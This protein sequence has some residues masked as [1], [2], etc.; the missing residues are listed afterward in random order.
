MPRLAIV[1]PEKCNPKKCQRE[2]VKICPVNRTKKKCIEVEKKAR[3]SEL[4]CIGCNQC[5][6]RCPFSAIKIV[7]TP[8][9][10]EVTPV[11]RYG[12]NGF[13][14]FNLPLPKRGQVLGLLG[15]NG[16]GKSTILNILS[17]KIELDSDVY[18]KF[19]G[20]TLQVFFDK[21]LTVS[22]KPQHVGRINNKRLVLE[23]LKKQG[24]DTDRAIELFELEKLLKRKINELSGGE[25]QRMLTA[26]AYLKDTDVYIFDEPS[27]FLDIHQRLNMSKALRELASKGKYVIVV[28]HD[29]TVLDYTTDNIC[30]M[31]GEPGAYG[32]V[33]PPISTKSAIN[34]YLEGFVDCM[35]VRFREYALDF[36]H[37]TDLDDRVKE[38]A[39]EGSKITLGDFNLD[40]VPG[41][42][43]TS[44][45]N[46]VVG[47]NGTG[48][49]TFLRSLFSK[50]PSKSYKPQI[51][52]PKHKGTVE[53]LIYS[54][55]GV[56]S[57]IFMNNVVKPLE[58][59]RMYNYTV[60]NLSG[61]EIQA[62]AVVLC[63]GTPADVYILDE[64]SAFLDC[65]KRMTLAKILRRF[66]MDTRK[67]MFIVDHD[68]MLLSILSDKVLV[69]SGVPGVK[70]TVDPPKAKKTGL[71][72]FLRD[73]D[74]TFRY[75]SINGRH[76]INKLGSQFDSEQKK[77]GIYFR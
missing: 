4:M 2:C 32:I 43:S 60:A 29:I 22:H 53:D 70:C 39:Y 44:E 50:F 1:D 13:Q 5:V 61:G 23:V 7:N 27:S 16:I 49:T 42:I 11:H 8:D 55:I 3:I 68:F 26:V 54:K 58:V 72:E 63:L 21:D 34:Q 10:L 46:S 19:Y 74:V 59:D 15:V 41:K 25:M 52:D 45:I 62:V 64:P 38:I 30:L 17:G 14:L 51:I 66:V 73:L 75:E 56:P 36:R 65:E 71:N 6:R 24:G 47:R 20:T 67:V 18:K 76:R 57:D 48:K 69:T 28:E 40:I 33:S 12:A 9:E 37:S 35:N 31:F 77:K